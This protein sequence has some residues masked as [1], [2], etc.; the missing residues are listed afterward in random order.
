M[1]RATSA[2][3]TVLGFV[4]MFLVLGAAGASDCGEMPLG[5]AVTLAC[6][7][8]ALVA[9]SVGVHKKSRPACWHTSRRKGQ[10]T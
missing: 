6:I 8:A 4:G 7:G 3:S 5:D 9:V 2:I 1:N 10:M